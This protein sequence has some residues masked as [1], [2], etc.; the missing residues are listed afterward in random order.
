MSALAE[1]L[2]AWHEFYLLLG[3]SAA[4]LTGLMFVVVSISPETIATRPF[5]GIRAFVTPTVVYFTTVLVV[6]GAMMAPHLGPRPL[7]LLL[8]LGG[9]AGV[10]YMLWI[11]VHRQWREAKLE[12]DDWVWYVALPALSYILLV[13]AAIALWL[14]SVLAAWTIGFTMVLLLVTGIR[15]GWDLALW[16]AQRRRP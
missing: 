10:A 1:E 4:A 5:A 12:E 15:N 14:D 8:G 2:H 11:D 3:T 7:A 16:M 13:A 6:S 9:I